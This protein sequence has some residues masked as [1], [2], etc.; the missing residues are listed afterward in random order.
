MVA[1]FRQTAWSNFTNFGISFYLQGMRYS[2]CNIAS[3][4]FSTF[5]RAARRDSA[6]QYLSQFLVDTNVLNQG[7]TAPPERLINICTFGAVN[8]VQETLQATLLHAFYSL[9]KLKD[10]LYLLFQKQKLTLDLS[11]SS[12]PRKQ[13]SKYGVT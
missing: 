4:E 11:T 13:V 2:K 3:S 8:L 10:M 9:N 1:I 6:S 12:Q 7:D 5:S